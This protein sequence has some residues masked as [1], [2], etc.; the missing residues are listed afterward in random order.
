MRIV[1][2][3]AL[4]S[5][6][7]LLA[8]PAPRLAGYLPSGKIADPPPPPPPVEPF[9]YNSLFLTELNAEQ[10]AKLFEAVGALLDVGIEFMRGTLNEH[11]VMT[12]IM[13]Y[14]QAIASEPVKARNPAE[15]KA[16]MDTPI[17]QFM[18]TEARR[19]AA[20]VAEFG[21]DHD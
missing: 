11:L 4:V 3:S 15:F 5:Y 21:G 16:L 6:P 10:R 14:R 7:F 18:I 2:Q 1:H 19:R 12:A 8:L 13:L 9:T 20:F 17:L